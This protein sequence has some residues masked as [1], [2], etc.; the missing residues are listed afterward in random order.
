VPRALR[1]VLLL[2]SLLALGVAAILWGPFLVRDQIEGAGGPFGQWVR[3]AG[4]LAIALAAVSLGRRTLLPRLARALPERRETLRRLGRTLQRD[5][6]IIHLTAGFLT[7][8]LGLLHAWYSPSLNPLIWAGFGCLALLVAMG[9][10]LQW[11][12]LPVLLRRPVAARNAKWALTL[13]ATVL[14]VWGHAQL[15]LPPGA[16]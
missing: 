10:G 12:F 3:A 7:L 11:G 2:G 4:L 16:R 5:G 8:G 13:A 1:A 15:P 14:I 9:V 6:D